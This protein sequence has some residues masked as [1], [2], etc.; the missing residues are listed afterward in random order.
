MTSEKSDDPAVPAIA[1]ENTADGDG[2]VGIGGR[3]VVG[4]ST[5]YQGVYGHS[6]TNAGVVGEADAFHGVF[7]ISHSHTNA[8]LFGTN[9]SPCA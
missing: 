3:G 2:V 7:G 5:D 4:K 6:G 8:G 9:D 1:G